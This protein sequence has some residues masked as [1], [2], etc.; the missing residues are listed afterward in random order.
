[1]LQHVCILNDML[2]ADKTYYDR[3]AS[4][5]NEAVFR[6]LLKCTGLR[7]IEL[8]HK[9][10]PDRVDIFGE[11]HSLPRL[12]S[13]SLAV[14]LSY[15]VK[16]KAGTKFELIPHMSGHRPLPKKSML[17]FKTGKEINPMAVGSDEDL[18]ECV[19]DFE[20]NFLVHLQHEINHIPS[21]WMTESGGAR[22]HENCT[23][24][25]RRQR[26]HD[27]GI[28]PPSPWTMFVSSPTTPAEMATISRYFVLQDGPATREL[29]LRDQSDCAIEIMGLPLSGATRI[30]HA[31]ER[32]MKI[33]AL[34]A[35]GQL[36][37]QEEINRQQ[38]E[39][40]RA[41]KRQAQQTAMEATAQERQARRAEEMEEQKRVA[42]EVRRDE[43][44]ARVKM[45]L[46]A[47]DL[48]RVERKRLHLSSPVTTGEKVDHSSS[49][50]VSRPS[51]KQSSKQS[52]KAYEK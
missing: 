41:E 24:A 45:Q 25:V 27:S 35:A 20:T 6:T 16:V 47:Q 37:V 40:R 2:G 22:K 38:I 17:W 43:R 31:R 7:T 26:R 48:R 32:L 4:A 15:E 30:R 1:M 33:Q 12:L 3:Y 14:V 23:P 52:Q 21:R 11:I 34:H 51:K 36:T 50:S 29:T 10:L 39:S 5:N 28:N 9:V 13:L 44:E 18:K 42:K 49:S 19:R 46:A 8:G